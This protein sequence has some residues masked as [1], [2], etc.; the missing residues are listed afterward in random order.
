MHNIYTIS[1]H[2][3][4]HHQHHHCHHHHHLNHCHHHH[5]WILILLLIIII[6][7]IILI[8][9]IILFLFQSTKTISLWKHIVT[10]SAIIH[11]HSLLIFNCSQAVTLTPF[12]SLL[13]NKSFCA[14]PKTVNTLIWFW[15]FQ[16]CSNQSE[17]TWNHKLITVTV[18][19]LVFSRVI[20]FL[21]ETH[22]ITFH[23]YF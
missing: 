14:N 7:I 9:I 20:G 16:L 22:A 18:G 17:A 12:S 10:S 5:Y 21:I 11:I 2:T 8:T 15:H 23:K 1:L 19:G 3:H 4:D 6:I 13:F